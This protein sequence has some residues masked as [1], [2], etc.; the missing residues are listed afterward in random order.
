MILPKTFR[1]ALIF[2]GLALGSFFATQ[3]SRAQENDPGLLRTL[4]IDSAPIENSYYLLAAFNND[5]SAGHGAYLYGEGQVAFTNDWGLYFEFPWLITRQPIG[6]APL[7]FGPIG[8]FLRYEAYHFGGWNDETAGAFSIQAG[9]SYGFPNTSFPLIGSS[10]TVEGFGGYRWGRF[11]L[12]EELGYQGSIDSK[13]PAQ[14][15]ANTGL[16]F[17]LTHEWYLQYE[18]DL[19][20][21]TVGRSS[22]TFIPQVAF[23]PGDWLFEFG[24][25]FGDSPFV[26]TQL[27]VARAL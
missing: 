5:T 12:Q 24:E 1:G 18:A 9:G 26:Y 17:R 21:P 23:Q 25:A 7:G 2:T 19:L 20:A 27:M 3:G 11:F 13:G 15:E 8:L 4:Q 10:W 14:W 22:W 6:Q 16:G